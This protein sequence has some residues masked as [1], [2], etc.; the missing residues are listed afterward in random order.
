MVTWT[1]A[2]P[3]LLA[4]ACASKHTPGSS[5]SVASRGMYKVGQ[6]YSIDGITYVPMEE[7]QH[8]ETVHGRRR[9]GVGLAPI[10]TFAAKP[11]E[12]VKG[13]VATSPS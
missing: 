8:V 2:S 7:F 5:G 12:A 3:F 11:V 4:G 6:P 10:P 9:A 1:G 13:G